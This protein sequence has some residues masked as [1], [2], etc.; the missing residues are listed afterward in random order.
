MGVGYAVLLCNFLRAKKLITPERV[1]WAMILSRLWSVR[2]RGGITGSLNES[3]R[4]LNDTS[5]LPDGNFLFRKDPPAG[6]RLRPD[7][8]DT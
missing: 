2:R 3:E 6:L 8:P 7:R 4:G 5:L 1:T